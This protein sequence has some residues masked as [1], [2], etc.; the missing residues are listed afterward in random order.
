MGMDG[1][2]VDEAGRWLYPFISWYDPR[3][4]PQ[5]RWWMEHIGGQKQFSITGNPVYRF[6]TALR[7]LW[8]AEHEPKILDRTA[9]WLLIEDFVNYMLCGKMATDFSMA[10]STLLF[11]QNTKNW[12]GELLNLSG[13][14]RRILCD[15]YPSGMVLGEVTPAAAQVTGLKTGTPV[16]L[17]GHDYLCGALPVGAFLPGVILDITGTWEIVLSAIANPV[18]TPEV[19]CMGMTVESH[20]AKGVYSVGG[21]ALAA[22]MLEWFRKEY[23]FE[24]RYKAQQKGGLDWDY[25]IAEAE[26]S[27]PGSHGV[28]FLPHISGGGCPVSDVRSMG[29]F[30]GL[31]IF[32]THGDTLRSIIEGLDYQ[33]LEILNALVSGVGI[34]PEKIVAVG[35]AVRNKFWMQNKANVVGREIEVPAVEEATPLGAAT[36]AGI[37]VGIY[38]DEKDA[39]EHIYRPG[40]V[41]EPDP[42][43]NSL[44]SELY[45]I[46]Q[47]LYERLKPVSYQIYEKFL[48]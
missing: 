42:K 13:I 25:I 9:K 11:D 2:P 41:Y 12:S 33:F 1:L 28:M 23:C 43:E 3:T 31:S 45:S 44:Y 34:Q 47:Q 32:A 26:T 8:M 21:G 14:D 37:G 7:L 5:Y 19:C 30:T 22:E 38:R 4:E 18:L 16:V 20:V 29:A 35:G 17:G 40:P 46:Y 36:L 10:S 6:N 15:P 27:P 24:A 48:A 39:Y